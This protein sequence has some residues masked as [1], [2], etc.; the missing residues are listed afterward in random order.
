LSYLSDAFTLKKARE[1]PLTS[2]TF[3]TNWSSIVSNLETQSTVE[4]GTR[5]QFV[6]NGHELAAVEVGRSG[7][8]P[9]IGAL[10]RALFALGVVVSAYQVRAL[11][12]GTVERIVLQRLDGSAISGELSVL[13][14]AAILPIALD[15]EANQA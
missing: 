6:E 7:R 12:G 11:P 3:V 5:V 2:G 14:R 13:T 8:S 1:A 15:T 4:T 10:H 9:V